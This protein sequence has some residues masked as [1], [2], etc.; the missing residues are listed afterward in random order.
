M[1]ES[2][3]DVAVTFRERG[4]GLHRIRRE[5]MILV[6]DLYVEFLFAVSDVNIVITID[7]GES[8]VFAKMP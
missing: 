5:S 8:G 6:D 3:F 7:G 1:E 2:S 4:M